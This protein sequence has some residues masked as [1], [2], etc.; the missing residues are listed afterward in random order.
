MSE[1]LRF[2]GAMDR[3]LYLR[4]LSELEGVPAAE[5]AQLAEYGRERSFRPGEILLEEGELPRSF[6][7]L[8][9]GRVEVSSE[10][11]VLGHAV[12]RQPVGL[13]ALIG[14]DENGIG[15]RA[16]EEVL[17]LEFGAEMLIDALEERFSIVQNLLRNSARQCLELW[18]QVDPRDSGPDSPQVLSCP[19]RP[20][21]L[22]ERIALLRN[23]APFREVGLDAL[24][25]LASQLEERRWE[26]GDVIF[27]AGELGHRIEIL[28]CG[29]VNCHHRTKDI[30]YT[31]MGGTAIGVLEAYAGVPRDYSAVAREHV[32][33]LSTHAGVMIDLMEDHHDIALNSL[34][35][36]SKLILH[37]G[38]ILAAADPPQ[39]E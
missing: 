24:A 30:E 14:R 12:A 1:R 28:I 39:P 27:A 18:A 7:V 21:D 16:V 38:R 11:L 9:R 34:A 4:T 26:E 6:F 37:Y 31:R 17:C 10:G 33:T 22:V 35:V 32:V 8:A 25:E 20:L 13:T 23:A 36:I 2:V 5:L 29:S 15:A 3:V 19:T